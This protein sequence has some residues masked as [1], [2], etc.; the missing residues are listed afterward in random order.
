MGCPLCMSL[1]DSPSYCIGDGAGGGGGGAASGG[2]ADLAGAS[3][4]SGAIGS[5]SGTANAIN[6]AT[7]ITPN[8]IF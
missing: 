2:G 6:P 1:T 7:E 8:I 5:V 3:I 4:A